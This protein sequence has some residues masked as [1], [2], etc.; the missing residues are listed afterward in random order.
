MIRSA[1]RAGLKK[2]QVIRQI[3][4]TN[5]S[6]PSQFYQAVEG[7]KGPVTLLTDQGPVIVPE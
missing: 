4:K 7:L 2:F 6:T 3:E 5:L 1:A